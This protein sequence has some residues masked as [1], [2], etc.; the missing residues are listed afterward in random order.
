MRA[1][2]PSCTPKPPLCVA[3]DWALGGF[4]GG[5]DGGVAILGLVVALAS[6]DRGG[7]AGVADPV[8]FWPE[9]GLFAIRRDEGRLTLGMAT[10]RQSPPP[11]RRRL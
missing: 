3:G 6:P 9:V 7:F 11:S 8:F 4:R 1:T 10:V 2:F 5:V